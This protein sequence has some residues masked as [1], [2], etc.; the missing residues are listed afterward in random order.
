MSRCA[1]I[2]SVVLFILVCATFIIKL[3]SY[4]WAEFIENPKTTVDIWLEQNN[5]GKYKQLF[6][7]K[8]KNI[9]LQ[10]QITIIK[11][12]LLHLSFHCL[13]LL[14]GLLVRQEAEIFLKNKKKIY[15][16]AIFCGF[17]Q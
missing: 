7:K 4:F 8:G 16:K 17:F 5:L 12:L 3:C 11:W 14:A 10:K 9:F 15:D 1:K 13:L 6:K 2:F